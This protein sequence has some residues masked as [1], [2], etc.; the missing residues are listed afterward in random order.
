MSGFLLDTNC[1]S[2]AVRLRPE[3]RVLSWLRANEGLLHVSVLTL[4]EIRKGI[5]LLP[6]GKKRFELEEW[7]E[8]VLPAKFSARLLPITAEV[9]EIWGAM[10][11]EAQLKGV[12]LATTDGLIAATAKHHDLTLVTRTVKDFRICGISVLNPRG[13]PQP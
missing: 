10:A 7:L 4:G 13:L 12:G 3:P 5:T 9:S 8:R 2:E 6:P 11:G 1:V